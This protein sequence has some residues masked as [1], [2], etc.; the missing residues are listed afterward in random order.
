MPSPN[1]V[2]APLPKVST[3]AYIALSL[4]EKLKEREEWLRTRWLL[5]GILSFSR[6]LLF[7]TTSGG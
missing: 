1:I 5:D 3:A 6:K 7:E 4:M 2:N